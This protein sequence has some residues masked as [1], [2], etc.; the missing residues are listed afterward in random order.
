MDY[1]N[2]SFTIGFYD[3]TLVTSFLLRGSSYEFDIFS[4]PLDLHCGVYIFFC[5]AT[6][7][8]FVLSLILTLFA[9]EL[10]LIYLTI[11]S[12]SINFNFLILFLC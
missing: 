10:E 8:I 2:L 3:F 1:L 12:V 7:F 9:Y 6:S 5:F 11:L 4:T